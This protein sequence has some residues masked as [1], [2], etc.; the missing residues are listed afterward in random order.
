MEPAQLGVLDQGCQQHRCLLHE[1]RRPLRHVGNGHRDGILTVETDMTDIGT[2]SYT[3]IAQTAA[4]IDGT[5]HDGWCLR[6][7]HEA[8][9]GRGRQA[10]DAA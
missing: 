2:G 3:I 8:E 5:G 4:E 6:R 1:R 10:R 9:K 7:L